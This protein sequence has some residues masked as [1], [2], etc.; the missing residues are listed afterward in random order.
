VAIWYIDPQSTES[1][2]FDGG[3]GTGKRRDVFTDVTG[4]AAGDRVA[5]K[6]LGAVAHA[7]RITITASGSEGNPIVI[8]SYGGGRATIDAQGGTIGTAA[9]LLSGVSHVH[10]KNLCGINHTEASGSGICALRSSN[11][12]IIGCEAYGNQIGI[13]VAQDQAA[14]VSTI[15]VRGNYCHDNEYNG[16]YVTCG[17]IADSVIG[18]VDIEYNRI[19]DNGYTSSTAMS[20][21]GIFARSLYTTAWDAARMPYGIRVKGNYVKRN[22]GYGIGLSG[23]KDG[24]GGNYINCNEVTETTP[25]EDI[26]TH[27]IWS[28]GENI[29][30]E[31]NNVHH[32]YGQT[33]G[34]AGSGVGVYCDQYFDGTNSVNPTVVGNWIHD[35]WQGTTSANIPSGGVYFYHATNGLCT[36]NLIERCRQGIV[37]LGGD[38]DGLAVYNNTVREAAEAGIAIATFA[39]SVVVKNNVVDGAELGIFFETGASA[40]TNCSESKNCVVNTSVHAMANGTFASPSAGTLDASDVTID[41]E[42]DSLGWIDANSSCYGQG[43]YLADARDLYGRPLR[44]TPDIGAFQYRRA[45]GPIVTTIRDAGW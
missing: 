1:D 34:S 19:S 42:L 44:A 9:V 24:G 41:P 10:V 4:L 11:V 45:P 31:R 26:D 29:S 7:G 3:F 6:D 22:R 27:C 32:N 20:R 30:H 36:G 25:T 33:G 21:G 13:R 38:L 14:T 37:A 23:V 43:E 12:K 2:S 28:N 5:F 35:Q 18:D 15:V 8:C 40:V 16:I 39:D 17:N